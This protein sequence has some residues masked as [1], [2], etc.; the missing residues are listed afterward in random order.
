MTKKRKILVSISGGRTSAM[1]AALIKKLYGATCEII[2][3]FANTSREEEATL[4][5]LDKVDKLFNLGVVWVEAVVHHGSRKSC[6]HRVV[7]FETACRDG[8]VFEEVIKK[9]GIPNTKFKHCTRELKT[10]TI[11]SYAKAAGFG[12]YGI[13]YETAIGYRADEPKRINLEKIKTQKHLYILNDAGIKKS[14]V[15]FFWSQQ[16]FDLEISDYE[17][18]CKLCLKKS[19]RKLLTTIVEHPEHT[20]WIANMENKYEQVKP[21]KKQYDKTPIRFFREGDSINDLIEES[22]F[23]FNKAIDKSKDTTGYN[24]A[25]SFSFDMDYEDVDCGSSCE[26]FA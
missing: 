4:I 13:G 6:T 15:A 7:T 14:D 9:Y 16:P 21:K 17:G 22:K 12:K 11:K 24:A 10:N 3:V 26:A 5:F 20:E 25:V 18:N 23:P 2:Y 19:K 8:S 1:M